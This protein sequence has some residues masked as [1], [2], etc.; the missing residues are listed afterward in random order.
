MDIPVVTTDSSGGGARE[1]IE[2]GVNGF[3]V[4]VN[5]YVSMA[6][7]MGLIADHEDIAQ[8]ISMKAVEIRTRLS[9]EEVCRQWDMIL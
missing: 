8:K 2:N 5:D 4:P 7:C 3:L 1:V 9:E 6:S